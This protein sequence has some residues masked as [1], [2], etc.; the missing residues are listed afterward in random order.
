MSLGAE[1]FLGAFISDRLFGAVP[2]ARAPRGEN[3]SGLFA[4][5]G[6]RESSHPERQK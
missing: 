2:L 1:S 6:N 4:S 3:D 5:L